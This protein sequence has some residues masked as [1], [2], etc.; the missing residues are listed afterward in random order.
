MFLKNLL[1]LDTMNDP[2]KAPAAIQPSIKAKSEAVPLNAILTKIGSP[3][4]AGPIM[5]RL[6]INVMTIIQ[7]ID[8]CS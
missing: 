5:K 3:T 4:M 1:R 6:L 7:K 2:T 8:F